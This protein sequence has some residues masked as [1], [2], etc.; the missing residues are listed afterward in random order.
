MSVAKQ[1]QRYHF[2]NSFNKTL[3]PTLKQ[4]AYAR[5]L[6]AG[7]GEG[8]RRYWESRIGWCSSR[9]E[10]AD[11]IRAMLTERRQLLYPDEPMFGEPPRPVKVRA[12]KKLPR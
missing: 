3:P 7:S 2:R 4:K 5:T 6:I 9:A 1:A 10:M 8:R 12:G 11:I